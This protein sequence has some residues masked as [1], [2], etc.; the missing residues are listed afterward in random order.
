MPPEGLKRFRA[1]IKPL[2]AGLER[3]ALRVGKE[4]L[5]HKPD[6][7]RNSIAKALKRRRDMKVAV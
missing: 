6:K 7:I 3:T 5:R 1:V 4:K 2:K